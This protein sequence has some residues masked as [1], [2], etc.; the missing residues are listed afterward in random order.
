MIYTRKP[1]LQVNSIEREINEAKSETVEDDQGMRW[2]RIRVKL[3]SSAID[4]VFTPDAGKAFGVQ[5]SFFSRHGINYTAANGT[6][7]ANYG[8]KTLKGYSDECCPLTV[9]V[10]IADVKSNLA[11]GMRII[12]ADN[13][14]ILDSTGSYIENKK[15][16]DR[17][18]IRHENG[19]FVFDMWVPAKSDNKKTTKMPVKKKNKYGAMEE[20]QDD[21]MDLGE[22]DNRCE[23]VFRRQE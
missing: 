14:I 13:R 16:G 3:D 10:Q 2:E 17:I 6:E 19:C 20:D 21:N 11:A 15:T 23:A 8:Q 12:E 7:I 9:N 1:Q 4:W 5:P 18:K 22:I